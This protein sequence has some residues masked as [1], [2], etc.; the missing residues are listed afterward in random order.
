MKPLA[1]PFA[2]TLVVGLAFAGASGLSAD[3][4]EAPAKGYG[5]PERLLPASAQ[6]YFRWDGVAAHREQ[7]AQ[8]ALGQLLSR[9]LAP[10][11]KELLELYPRLLRSELTEKKLL[12]G[13]PPDRLAKIHAAVGESG[14]LL[15][16]LAEHGIVAAA[17]VSPLPSLYQMAFGAA[18]MA[19]GKKS[20][21]NPLMPRVQ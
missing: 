16:V 3:K 11:R 14:K 8:T 9:D 19:F 10:L 21:A 13:L 7:Y 20:D 18:Q 12:E 6:V 4:P 15:D 5:P 17:E 1:V 2:A